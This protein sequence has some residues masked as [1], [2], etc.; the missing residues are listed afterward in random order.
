MKRRNSVIT[1]DGHYYSPPIDGD[2]EVSDERWPNPDGGEVSFSS[3]TGTG[4]SE[5]ITPAFL[6]WLLLLLLLRLEDDSNFSS[7]VVMLLD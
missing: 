6:W 3:R 5:E 4:V 1:T 2:E 7:A